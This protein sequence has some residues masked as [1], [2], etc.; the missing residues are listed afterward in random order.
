VRSI[1]GLYPQNPRHFAEQ[2]SARVSKQC[3]PSS[4][5]RSQLLRKQW[6]TGTCTAQTAETHWYTRAR[7]WAF[8]QL[9]TST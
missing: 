4:V 3:C 5:A 9:V 6:I 8:S 7:I 1:A 2:P